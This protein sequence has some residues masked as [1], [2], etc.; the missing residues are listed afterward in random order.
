[1]L[2]LFGQNKNKLLTT[3]GVESGELEHFLYF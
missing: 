3:E 2:R 1:M